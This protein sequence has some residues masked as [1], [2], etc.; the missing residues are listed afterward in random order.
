ML[1]SSLFH[2]LVL[3]SVSSLI[4]SCCH[5]QTSKPPR[6]GEGGPGPHGHVKWQST[7][8]PNPNEPTGWI[9]GRSVANLVT[10]RN[11]WVNWKVGQ[12]KGPVKPTESAS[13]KANG[14]GPREREGILLFDGGPTPGD[15]DTKTDI[16]VPKGDCKTVSCSAV[17]HVE[18]SLTGTIET[19][20]IQASSVAEKTERGHQITYE[21]E[22]DI[23]LA[24]KFDA[25]KLAIRWDSILSPEYTRSLKAD[26]RAQAVYLPTAAL[27]NKTWSTR[28]STTEPLEY[29]NESIHIQYAGGRQSRCWLPAIAPKRKLRIHS[30]KLLNGETA[31]IVIA[32][33]SDR[34]I[35]LENFALVNGGKEHALSDS[36]EVI[37][38]ETKRIR[39]N[40]F[41]FIGSPIFGGLPNRQE[42]LTQLLLYNHMDGLLHQVQY[43]VDGA[44]PRA[45]FIFD[46]GGN[47]Q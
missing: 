43:E 22:F 42:N 20:R 2:S 46:S 38:G 36:G 41:P 16:W 7:A 32:N 15:G 40:N 13:S 23:P 44:K 27:Q 31:E 11:C 14:Y 34:P 37:Q 26:L 9:F 21:L 3:V 12:I 45:E 47:V 19:I 18:N 33:L 25:D 28:F 30:L 17:T 5:G 4:S 24:E 8:T 10:D 6:S 1:R 35:R 39:I 29:R